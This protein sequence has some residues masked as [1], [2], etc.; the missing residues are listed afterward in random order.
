MDAET[1]ISI[2]YLLDR[3]EDP[4]KGSIN[5]IDS[6]MSRSCAISLQSLR[7][8]HPSEVT[9]LTAEGWKEPLYALNNGF[10]RERD[11]LSRSHVTAIFNYFETSRRG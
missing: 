1:A 4:S 5:G 8:L 2:D 11:A 3:L 6:L 9:T 10:L 7:S